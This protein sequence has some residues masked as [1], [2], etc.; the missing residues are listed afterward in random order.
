MWVMRVVIQFVADRKQFSKKNDATPTSHIIQRKVAAEIRL[1]NNESKQASKQAK[2]NHPAS[3]YFNGDGFGPE[4]V[5]GSEAEQM[6]TPPAGPAAQATGKVDF[7][8]NLD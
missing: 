3:T 5:L 1:I 2:A 6:L 7:K 4:H 8:P